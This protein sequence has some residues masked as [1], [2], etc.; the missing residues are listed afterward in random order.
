MEEK[1]S[2][3]HLCIHKRM[4]DKSR[5]DLVNRRE[6]ISSIGRLYHLER[7]YVILVLKEMEAL[8]L[9]EV[10]NRSELK[11]LNNPIDLKDTSRLYR[12]AGLF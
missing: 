4:L 3:L 2:I 11:I 8:K 12:K 5:G 10:A 6:A 9:I 1:I 7:K